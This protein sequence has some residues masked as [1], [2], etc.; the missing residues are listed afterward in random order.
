MSIDDLDRKAEELPYQLQQL[1]DSNRLTKCLLE[2]PIFNRLYDED[3]AIDLLQAWQKCGGFSVAAEMY[4]ESLS[5]L[6]QSGISDVEYSDQA[7]KVAMF[8]I[9]GGQYM[10]AYRVLEDCVSLNLD[11]R[12]RLADVYALMAQCRS[13]HLNTMMYSMIYEDNVKEREKVVDLCRKSNEYRKQLTGEEHEYKMAKNNN[14]LS[15]NLY[16]SDEDEEA[17]VV[18][19]EAI[20]VFEKF[21]DIGMLARSIKRKYYLIPE[22]DKKAELMRSRELCLRAY[23][24]NHE[25]YGDICYN[26]GRLH[27]FYFEEHELAYN[28]LLESEQVYLKLYGAN[29]PETMQV[30]RVIESE[31]FED[32]RKQRERLIPCTA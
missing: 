10:E 30:R 15:F 6:K 11:E 12:G 21:N 24:K 28:Y 22:V 8:L 26:L 4:K 2:W 5:L 1:L 9:Q 14:Y 16:H 19:N 20:A 17:L 3:F 13:V 27:E 25:L 32:I 18:I 23:G 31:S 7:Q 29:H